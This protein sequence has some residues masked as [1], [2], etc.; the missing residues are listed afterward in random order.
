[1]HLADLTDSLL[2]EQKEPQMGVRWVERWALQSAVMS[3]IQKA[4]PL[5]E[6]SAQPMVARSA[7]TSVGRTAADLAVQKAKQK[8]LRKVAHSGNLLARV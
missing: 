3:G 1:M 5:A 7:V 2:V 6:R 4:G 8:V